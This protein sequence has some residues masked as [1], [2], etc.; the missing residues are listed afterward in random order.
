MNSVQCI[1]ISACLSDKIAVQ[2]RR[3]QSE[4]SQVGI[5]YIDA[6]VILILSDMIINTMTMSTTRRRVF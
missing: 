3:K 4:I 2:S 6:E 1:Y 5:P